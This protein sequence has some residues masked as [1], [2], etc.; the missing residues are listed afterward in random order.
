MNATIIV[1]GNEKGG[2]GKSTTAMH[3]I[4][5][6]MHEGYTVGAIDLDARQSTLA[7]YFDTRRIYG[8]KKGVELS[9]PLYRA[10][11]QSQLQDRL[12]AEEADRNSLANTLT[13]MTK[14][15][16]IVVIDTPGSDSP[17]S[18]IGHSYADILVTPM[19]DSFVDLDLLGRIDPETNEV[20][21]LSDYAE[22]VWEQK[23]VRAG[24]DGG[25]IDWIVMRN[26]LAAL[27]SRNKRNMDS[28]LEALSARLGFRL[29]HGF[30]ER[31]IFRE[32]FLKGLTLLDIREQGAD[33]ALTMSHIAALQEVRNLLHALGVPEVVAAPDVAASG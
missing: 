21:A 13:E 8:A 1:L 33:V 17:L 14:T 30:S 24:R 18:R 11:A 27:D 9:Y 20:V 15:C 7:R 12:A 22:M 28:A 4:V 6:L 10:I 29:A 2:T 26:R 31:V 16:D 32:L 19:N 25:S 23:K 3:I 5:G